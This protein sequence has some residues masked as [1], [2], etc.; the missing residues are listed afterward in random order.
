[1]EKRTNALEYRLSV[2]DAFLEPCVIPEHMPVV[3]AEPQ[4]SQPVRIP[5]VALVALD[6]VVFEDACDLS[7]TFAV[8]VAHK[9][10]PAPVVV[11]QDR[12]S[13]FEL[14]TD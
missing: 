9:F 14:G 4:V 3:Y 2:Q 12:E 6:V 10:A 11:V 13:T 7:V 5:G 8:E 1:M